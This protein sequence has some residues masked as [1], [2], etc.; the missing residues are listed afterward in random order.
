MQLVQSDNTRITFYGGAGEVTGVSIL[1]E[2]R[3]GEEKGARILL[4][5]G[6]LQREHAC[7]ATNAADFAFA[8]ASLDALVVSHAHADH[9]GRIPR[10]VRHGFRGHIHSTAPTKELAAL[11]FEDAYTIMRSE[12]DTHGCELLYEHKDITQALSQWRVYGY[13]EPVRL[14]DGVS[15]E[16]LDAG[17]IL[18]SAMVRLTRAGRTLLFTGDLGNS[19]EPLLRDTESPAGAE[20]LI[21]E[22]VYGDRAHEGRAGRK[23]ALRRAIEDAR[24]RKGTLLI[25]S[26]SIER[27][28]ILLHEIN[29]M[30]ESGDLAPIPVYLDSPLAIRVTDVYRRFAA[31]LNDEVQARIAAGDD[32]FDFSGL[33]LTPKAEQSEGIHRAPDPKIIIAGSGMSHGGRIREHERRYL[34]DKNAAVLFV[35]YQ[36]PGSL[37]RRIRDGAKEVSIDGVRV[38]VRAHIGEVTGYSGHKDR[39][40]LLAFA[41]QAAPTLKNVFVALGETRSSAFLAQRI[42]DFLD[43]ETVVPERGASYTIEW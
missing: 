31:Y 1:L 41:E 10:L 26:F 32:P 38:K 40:A 7:D 22:S 25:P 42:R 8:P 20:Y 27:T 19:P 37:G 12:A 34:S 21:T 33:S 36:S 3:G 17:H 23:E 24:A 28:Q 43:L 14:S 35:G 2:T 16:F 29:S 18:G 30:V 39:D 5:C 4:D 9:I 6:L 11:M 13:H 15:A